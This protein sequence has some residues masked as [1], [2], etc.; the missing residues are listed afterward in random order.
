MIDQVFCASYSKREGSL[1]ID[2]FICQIKMS[3]KKDYRSKGLKY[4]FH[5]QLCSIN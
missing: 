5:K 4:S 2:I 3:P 1:L